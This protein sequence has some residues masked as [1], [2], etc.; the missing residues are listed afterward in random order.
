MIT[1]VEALARVERLLNCAE[2]NQI[3]IDGILGTYANEVVQLAKVA[4]EM[5]SSLGVHEGLAYRTHNELLV[6]SIQSYDKLMK[7]DQG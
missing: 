2:P 6:E 7:G 4:A 3:A 1:F 5:R